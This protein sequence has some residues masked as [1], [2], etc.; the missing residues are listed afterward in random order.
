MILEMLGK[1]SFLKSVLVWAV[2]LWVVS[3]S[4]VF[5]TSH[6]VPNSDTPVRDS[7]VSV[8]SKLANPLGENKSFSD[9]VGSVAKIAFRIGFILAVIFIIYSGLKFVMARGNP[10]ELEKAKENLKYVL[11]GTAILLGAEVIARVV[12]ATISQLGN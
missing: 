10:G 3:F 6:S 11:I 1:K 12:K 8:G 9:L 5:A 4:P 2:F 7:G